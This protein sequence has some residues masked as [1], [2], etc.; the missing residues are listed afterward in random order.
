MLRMRAKATAASPAGK[1]PPSAGATSAAALTAWPPGTRAAAPSGKTARRPSPASM[2]SGTRPPAAMSAVP[3]A[4]VSAGPAS[5]RM[6]TNPSGRVPSPVPPV[7]LTRPRR[8]GPPSAGTGRT[9]APSVPVAT[10]SWTARGKKT[11]APSA[12]VAM[13]RDGL[14]TRTASVPGTTMTATA[15]M[16]RRPGSAPVPSPASMTGRAARPAAM[17]AAPTATV[18]ASPAS[19]RMR[20]GPSAH[21]PSPVPPVTLTRPRRPAPPSAGTGR[22]NVP[23]VPV[24]TVS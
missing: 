19:G 20:T 3:T 2:T 16:G 8:P 1:T 4:T 22:T 13:T 24:A 6:P 5:G 7:T 23:S 11:V 10:V 21:A 9:N 12:R 14:S 18:S 15:A 17:S